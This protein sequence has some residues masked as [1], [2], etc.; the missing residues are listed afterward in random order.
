MVHY[1]SFKS[2]NLSEAQ[3]PNDDQ[4]NLSDALL[5]VNYVIISLDFVLDRQLSLHVTR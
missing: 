1:D 5:K 2:N 4:V 3:M